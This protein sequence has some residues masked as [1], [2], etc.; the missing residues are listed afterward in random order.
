MKKIFVSTYDNFGTYITEGF[1]PGDRGFYIDK[2][3]YKILKVIKAV[4]S[5]KYTEDE[6]LAGKSK[7]GTLCIDDVDTTADFVTGEGEE[8]YV[9]FS[10]EEL[11]AEVC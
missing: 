2:Y 9:Y 8:L 3:E 6:L 4:D 5:T 7:D 1:K 11:D 10:S